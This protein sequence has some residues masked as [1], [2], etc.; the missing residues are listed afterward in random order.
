MNDQIIQYIEGQMTM[1]EKESFEMRL[2]SDPTLAE[3]LKYTLAA[4]KAA[5]G[6]IEAEVY[7][8]I[9]NFRQTQPQN[10]FIWKK[11]WVWLGII[12]LITLI[13]SGVFYLKRS[14]EHV[15][16]DPIILADN[17]TAP[18]WPLERSE[19][20]AISD[21]VRLHLIGQ[22]EKALELLKEQEKEESIRL[23]WT[24][25]ILIDAGRYEEAIPI[26]NDLIMESEAL[27]ARVKLLKAHCVQQ[28][29]GKR[30]E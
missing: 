15:E 10:Q 16:K 25:E 17:Y 23:Y 30:G 11:L 4:Q 5:E 14:Q 3:Q 22:T 24:A 19:N 2:Q 26:L 9:R 28:M 18:I 6:F 12:A 1:E 7:Q 8:T 21:A 29:E 20:N 27:N 13:F